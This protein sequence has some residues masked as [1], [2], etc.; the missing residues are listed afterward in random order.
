MEDMTMD[1]KAELYKRLAQIDGNMTRVLLILESDRR[2]N[3]QGVVEKLQVLEN[4]VNEMEVQDRIRKS[5]I[6]IYGAIGSVI[7]MALVFLLKQVLIFLL[8]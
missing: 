3:T 4:R 7:A 2:T 1:E 5:Q 8:K 6:A